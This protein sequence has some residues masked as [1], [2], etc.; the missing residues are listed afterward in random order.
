MAAYIVAIIDEHDAAGFKEYRRQALPVVA[1]YGGR[2]LLE[3]TRHE[4]LEGEWAPKRVVVIEFPSMESAKAFYASSEYSGP[5]ALRLRAA[6]TDMLLFEGRP[7][8]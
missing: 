6:H 8:A 7:D 2:S 5:K 3:G 1:A 4:R